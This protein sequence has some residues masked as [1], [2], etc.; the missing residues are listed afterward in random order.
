[1]N[2]MAQGVIMALCIFLVLLLFFSL[3]L[4]FWVGFG[5]MSL[6]GRCQGTIETGLGHSALFQVLYW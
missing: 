2:G 5:V 4:D 6:A 1:M 3:R